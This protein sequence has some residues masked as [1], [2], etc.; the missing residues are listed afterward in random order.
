MTISILICTYN[1]DGAVFR[2]C[3]A[4]LEKALAK[5]Q[6]H[7]ILFVDNNSNPRV[8]SHDF[9]QSFIGRHPNSRVVIE[10]TQ[11]LTPARLRAIRD[12]SGELL[13]FVDDDN[14]VREDFLEQA[15]RI[16][17][18]YPFIGAY[19]GQVE[20]VPETPP[21]NWTKRYWGMLVHRLFEGNHWG[22]RV[23]DASIMPCGAGLCVRREAAAYYCDLHQRGKRSIQLDRTKDS[24]LSGGDNDL[25]MCACDVGMGMGIFENL[26]VWHHIQPNRFTLS[27]LSRL[28]HG[29]YYSTTIL[30]FMRSGKIEGVSIRQN[31]KFLLL[32]AF[33]RREDFVITRSWIKGVNDAEKLL[34]N[35]N[36][37]QFL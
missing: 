22:N 32:S 10:T 1:P 7:E 26:Y 24:L 4:S 2:K 34:R 8:G 15:L 35:S 25:A 9:I 11:G 5:Q 31:L 33:R 30:K 16:A 29:I 18:Q 36:T 21:P 19:S 14:L 28:A 23:F 37:F 20:L 6:V 12:S 27:Y 13:V 17:I 3:L